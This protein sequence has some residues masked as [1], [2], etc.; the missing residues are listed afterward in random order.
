MIGVICFLTAEGLASLFYQFDVT[1][2]YWDDW[3]RPPQIGA[4][5]CRSLSYP[6]PSGFPA[7]SLAAAMITGRGAVALGPLDGRKAL[8]LG[9]LAEGPAFGTRRIYFLDPG[10]AED[11]ARLS[12]YLADRD[13]RFVVWDEEIEVPRPL[14][15]LS[16]L[17]ESAAGGFSV[18]AFHPQLQKC[19]GTS[20]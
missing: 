9:R 13:I 3:R 18:L 8:I 11:W 7:E 12:A 20:P 15:E 10:I 19:T 2:Q 17:R 14:R 4:R 6:Y 5:L 16:V 1:R